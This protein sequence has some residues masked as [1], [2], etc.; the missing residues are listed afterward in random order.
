MPEHQ[1]PENREIDMGSGNY[2]EQIGRDYYDNRNYVNNYSS[3]P[4]QAKLNP[5]NN[6]QC[7]GSTNFVGRTHELTILR[8]RLQQI[9]TVPLTA[10]AG[11]GGVGKTELAIQ[12]ARQHET[13]Y[14][15][16]ICWLSARKS[17][18][19][20]NLRQFAQL[21]MNLEVPQ[22]DRHGRLLNLTQQ[23]EWCWQNWQ[24]S[25]G[26]A[27]IVL[28]DVTNVENFRHLLPKANRFRVLITT[29]LRNLDANIEEISLDVL[30]LQEA[31]QLLTAVMDDKRVEEE[32]II[33]QQ[34][35]EWLGYL[36][37]GLELV[38]RYVAKKPPNYKLARMLQKLN[39]QRLDNEAINSSSSVMQQS[40]STAQLGVLATFELS[41]LSLT[42]TTQLVAAFLSLFAL[43]IFAWK[44]VESAS[45]SLNWSSTDVETANEQL[46]ELYLI[47]SVEDTSGEYKIRIH[48][49]I[50]E[51][52]LEKLAA[53][54]E[55]DDLKRGFAKVMVAIAKTISNSPTL[56]IITRVKDA[57]P[58][59]MKV[60]QNLTDAVS[61][62]N[63]I[64]VFYGLGRFYSGQGLYA[65]AEPWLEQCV[66]VVQCR[67]GE[68]HT[69]VATSFNNLAALYASQ[70]KY[71]RAEPLYIKALELKQRLLEESHP[72]VATSFNNLA[73]LYYSQ[74]K[75]VEAEPLY[76]KA[77]ELRQRLLEESHPDVATSFNNLAALYYSQGKYVEAGELYIKA[78]E[79][80]QQL[81]DESHPDVATSFNNLAALYYSQGKYVEAEPLYVKALELRQ[82]LLGE[83]HPEVATSFNNLA[84]LYQ[85]QGKYVEAEPIYV[86]A[87]ELR[88]RLLGESHPEVAMSFNNLAGLYQS[89]GKY[90]DAEQLYIKA[91]ENASKSLGVSHPNTITICENLKI[92][93]DNHA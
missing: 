62:D 55:A 65:L 23:V 14:P 28:D 51:F 30:S 53:L 93:R 46:Y 58:H 86:K 22:K 24:P 43:N 12:Y 49:L 36:P 81:L 50:R 8:E 32:E 88:Q 9:G 39:E 79:L 84:E 40:L 85:S 64:S 60:A 83:S 16:G 52:L 20:A 42:P 63:L 72:E 45:E 2:N 70:G 37:L 57:I 77:L 47:Q 59:L 13:D 11:M 31:L 5:P 38:G 82:R 1:E 73:A 35:C 41:W 56:E 61:D 27:L 90:N 67:L 80:R 92:L 71:V 69:H 17:D 89:Q 19:A 18:L 3:E 15:G 29:R 7:T 26:L 76:I 10:I 6:L 44:W 68:S 33:A 78:L 34:L 21:H 91:L 48:H 25:E 54:Q 66:S 75:Y 74:G 4:E 87:L